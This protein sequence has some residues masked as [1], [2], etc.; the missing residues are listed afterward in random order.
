MQP[1]CKTLEAGGHH[2]VLEA[3]TSENTVTLPPGVIGK[4]S[5]IGVLSYVEHR[6]R[7]DGQVK[8]VRRMMRLTP[9]TGDGEVLGLVEDRRDQRHG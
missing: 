3:Q 7:P 6:K 9:A 4:L 8:R 5:G 1:D 2:D